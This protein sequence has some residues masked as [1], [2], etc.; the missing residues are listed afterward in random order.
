MRSGLS[1]LDLRKRNFSKRLNGF[2]Q[3]EVTQ[4]VETLA[5]DLEDLYRKLDELERDNHHLK[6]ENARHRENEATLR[7]TLVMAQKSAD[8]FRDH[9]E[10]ESRAIITEAERQSERLMQQAMERATDIDR[11]IRELRIE[12]RNFQIKLQGMIDLFQQVLN[13]DREEDEME[14]S[15]TT[16]RAKKADSAS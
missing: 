7:E 4:F 1:P 12:R 9:A 14:A 10:R 11:K 13:F 6:Q 8:S 2:D 16:M 15:L 5:E 3:T